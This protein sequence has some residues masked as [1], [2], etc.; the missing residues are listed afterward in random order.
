M[1][2][3]H[4]GVGGGNGGAGMEGQQQPP[5]VR[6]PQ[7]QQQP[8]QQPPQQ[9]QQAGGDGQEIAYD[10]EHVFQENGKEVRK[11]P[12]KMGNNTF[13]VDVVDKEEQVCML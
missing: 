10:V 4:P 3:P 12:I 8:G 2:P 11:M 5:V 1:P 13:W 6:M 7:Q 9:Q